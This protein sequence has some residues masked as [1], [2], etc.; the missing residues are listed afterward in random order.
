MRCVGIAVLLMVC[1]LHS[2]GVEVLAQEEVPAKPD[3]ASASDIYNPPR[4]ITPEYEAGPR[5]AGEDPPDIPKQP[6]A[7][8]VSEPEKSV[9]GGCPACSGRSRGR[10]GGG[11]EFVTGYLLADLDDINRQVRRMGIPSL[12]D[13]VFLVGGR[14]YTRIGRL[15]VGGAGYSGQTESGG[16][17]DCCARYARVEIAYGGV[18][19]GLAVTRSRYEAQAGMLFG[20]G[21]IEVLRER[22]SRTVAGWDQAWENF[23]ETGPDSVATEDLNI[24]SKITGEFIALEPFAEVKYWL[25]PFMALD[26]S[27]SYLNAEVGRGEWKLDGVSIPDSPESNIGGWSLRLGLHFGI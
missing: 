18:I 9:E 8:V 24:T 10:V 12:S 1:V 20:G 19:L 17:P 25:L 13:D 26:V 7:P 21:S 15:L 2:A 22:N 3:T 11:G 16:I 14:G 23:D 5:P 4:V 6:A 27:A